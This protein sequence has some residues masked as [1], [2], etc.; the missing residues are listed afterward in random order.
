LPFY[1]AILEADF[2]FSLRD[3]PIDPIQ[4]ATRLVHDQRDLHRQAAHISSFRDLQGVQDDYVVGTVCTLTI[5]AIAIAPI[6]RVSQPL[7]LAASVSGALL[8]KHL[9]RRP[10]KASQVPPELGK[11]TRDR[12]EFHRSHARLRGCSR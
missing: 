9:A 2:N 12:R 8:P 3:Q 7:A 6:R 10:E 5:E 11:F 4:L 1:P